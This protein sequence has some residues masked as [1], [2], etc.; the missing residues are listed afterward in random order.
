MLNGNYLIV[1]VS[2][3][4]SIKYSVAYSTL[5]WNTCWCFGFRGTLLP[6]RYATL[7]RPTSQGCNQLV[8][9]TGGAISDTCL[10]IDGRWQSMADGHPQATQAVYSPNIDIINS[11]EIEQS[12]GSL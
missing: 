3:F 4:F 1:S 9:T 11:R 8:C 6:E 7:P 5:D 12:I 2:I 10:Y